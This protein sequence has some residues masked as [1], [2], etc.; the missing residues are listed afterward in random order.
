MRAGLR[1]TKAVC[2][3]QSLEVELG[4]YLLEDVGRVGNTKSCAPLY[5]FPPRAATT[6]A[7]LG[8]SLPHSNG[9]IPGNTQHTLLAIV[10]TTKTISSRR[11]TDYCWT[12]AEQGPTNLR[13]AEKRGLKNDC[14]RGCDSVKPRPKKNANKS[15]TR[16]TQR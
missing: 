1:N 14:T 9:A 8:S 11:S 6:L 12:A 16:Q 15:A 5:L 10:H 13:H 3:P 2:T 4:L 7:S